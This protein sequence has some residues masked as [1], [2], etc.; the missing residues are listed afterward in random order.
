MRQKLTSP[1]C[2]DAVC[3]PG[4]RKLVIR[5][6]EAIGFGIEIRQ[7]TKGQSTHSNKTYWHYLTTPA[8]KASQIKI[9]RYGDISFEAAKRKSKEL[10]SSIVLGGD[11]SRERADRKAIPTYAELARQHLE[12]AR[13]FHRRPEN[14]EVILRKYLVPEFGKLPINMIQPQA[15]EAYLA[16]LRTR[17]AMATVEKIRVVLHR[18]FHL[19]AKWGLPGGER[20]P[21]AAVARPRFENK[22]EMFV[23]RE[24]AARLLDACAESGNTMLRPIVHLLLLTGA[25]RGELLTARWEYVDIERRHWRIPDSKTG[26]ARYVPLSQAA[27]D[28]IAGLPKYP[29]CPWLVPNPE[30]RVPF[31]SIKHSWDT[32]R[33]KADLNKLRL[34]DLRH[35]FCS[36]AVAAGVD[37]VSLGKIVGH[38]DI[39]STMRYSHVSNSTLLS[40]VE[41]GAAQMAV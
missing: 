6:V 8:G 28:V 36:F 9:G 40:A 31:D 37:L 24:E 26:K 35:S 13:T 15:I 41:A 4:Q 5:C 29:G 32:A 30:T 3:P 38:A 2:R 12:H 33:K 34:H 16:K 22:R 39:A 10:R 20:S 23:N 27:L 11:P 7:S 25:R 18:S 21:L 14:T 17:L 19:A 1:L